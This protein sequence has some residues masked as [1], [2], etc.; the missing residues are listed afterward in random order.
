MILQK[1][2]LPPQKRNVGYLFQEYALFPTMTAAENISIVMKQ[3]NPV[4]VQKWLEEYG[5]GDYADSY[6]DHLSG[7]Q[8]QRLAMIRMLAAEPQ[9]ILLD[10]PFSALDEHIKR[11]MEREV[12]EM[13]H[14]FDKPILLFRIIR[15]RFIAWQTGSAAW[16]TADSVR[17]VK[18]G[19]FCR[20]SDSRAGKTG[21]LQ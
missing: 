21:R 19:D 11:K 10:E 18:R 17:S 16:K 4:Q 8:K 5:L 14:D 6:P 1:I 7:G 12:M 20:A 2:N 9:C 15:K 13:L 3:K